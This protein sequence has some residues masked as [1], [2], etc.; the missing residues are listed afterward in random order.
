M[1]RVP[2]KR[3]FLTDET[4]NYKNTENPC[5]D[6]NLDICLVQI[7]LLAKHF[8]KETLKQT[9]IRLLKLNVGEE[10]PTIHKVVGGVIF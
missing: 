9:H 5:H 3:D 10:I 8:R 1:T 4:I 6:S 7:F 2:T